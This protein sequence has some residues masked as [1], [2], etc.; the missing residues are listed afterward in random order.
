MIPRILRLHVIDVPVHDAPLYEKLLTLEIEVSPLKRRDLAYAKTE[1]LCHNHHRSV[2]FF[3][4]TEDGFI[5]LHSQHRRA[6]PP[7]AAVLDPDDLDGVATVVEQFP[8]GR[9]L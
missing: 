9:A 3:Q 5:L 7:L 1:A 8:A 2:R 6:L 4:Q